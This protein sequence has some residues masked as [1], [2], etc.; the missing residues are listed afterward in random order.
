ML[1]KI[2]KDGVRYI[3][4]DDSYFQI[5]RMIMSEVLKKDL[6]RKDR[7]KIF[8]AIPSKTNFCVVH[9][10]KIEGRN[11]YCPRCH[12]SYCVECLRLLIENEDLY[13]VCGNKFDP[14]SLIDL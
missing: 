13:W 11:Q 12:A 10:K 8:S 5:I 1:V 9:N 3:D 14:E 7:K 6:E 4:I 2:I